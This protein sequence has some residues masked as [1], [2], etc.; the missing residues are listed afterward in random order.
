VSNRRDID[1]ARV[2]MASLAMKLTKAFGPVEA[3]NML[4]GAALGLLLQTQGDGVAADYFTWLSDQIADLAERK[5]RE[6]LQ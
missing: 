2:R 1:A 6:V 3:V 4:T 5:G